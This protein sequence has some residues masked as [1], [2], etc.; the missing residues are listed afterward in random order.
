[1]HVCDVTMLYAA[2]SGGVRRYVDTKRAWLRQHPEHSHTL[3]IPAARSMPM[4]RNMPA[5]AVAAVA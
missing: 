3:M 4:A 5:V 2:E 1:M